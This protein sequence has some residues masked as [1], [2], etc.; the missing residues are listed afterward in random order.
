MSRVDIAA[1]DYSFLFSLSLEIVSPLVNV[2]TARSA[3][4]T[5]LNVVLNDFPAK[6]ILLVP[7]LPLSL[8]ELIM[9]PDLNIN[10]LASDCLLKLCKQIHSSHFLSG[11]D[12]TAFGAP[13]LPRQPKS[14]SRLPASIQLAD[15]EEVG[16]LFLT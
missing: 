7:R 12:H 3:L 16:V 13:S 6:C 1:S 10:L 15:I 2:A 14:M 4:T 5:I 9:H 11:L 8:V